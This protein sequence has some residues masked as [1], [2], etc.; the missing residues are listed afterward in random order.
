[1][2]RPS[3]SRS[4]GSFHG[5]SRN[6]IGSFQGQRW[7]TNNFSRANFSRSNFAG[8]NLYRTSLSR[9]NFSGSNLRAYNNFNRGTFASNT[10]SLRNNA[11]LRSNNLGGQR[12]LNRIAD[13][14]LVTNNHRN[15]NGNWNGNGTGNWN[16]HH[17]HHGGSSIIFIGG[18]G[19]PYYFPSYYDYYPY[20]YDPYGYGD[21]GYGTY[22]S[23]S[24][25]YSGGTY[26]GGGGVYQGGDPGVYQDDSNYQDDQ[27]GGNYGTGSDSSVAEVQRVL[28]RDGF[29]HGSIDGVAGSRTF[30]AIRAYQRSHNLHADGQISR[31]LLDAMGLR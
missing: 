30:Y 6:S 2:S 17:H 12:N 13:G 20:S 4:V 31:E 24:Y 21:Y 1:M 8:S 7:A 15:G 14:R 5:V 22:P 3:V 10:S 29:Y 23:A 16:H 19:Y 25:A 28:S 27:S 9:T 18:F 26:D 11:V